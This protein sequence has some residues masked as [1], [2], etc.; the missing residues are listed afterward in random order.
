MVL[1][2]SIVVGFPLQQK[3]ANDLHYENDRH[4]N[5]E[6]IGLLAWRQLGWKIG[7]LTGSFEVLC[8]F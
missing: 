5:G 1:L 8:F 4:S 6:S 3:A 2:A 7:W